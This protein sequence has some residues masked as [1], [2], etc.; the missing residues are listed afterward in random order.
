M[1]CSCMLA[2][3]LMQYFALL[4]RMVTYF[5]MLN[6]GES[7]ILIHNNEYEKVTNC[8]ELNPC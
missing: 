3:P 8:R 1:Y 6:E 2:I 7:G 4:Y 5:Q